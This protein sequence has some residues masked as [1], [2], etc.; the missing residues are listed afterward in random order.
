MRLACLVMQA[1]RSHW[2]RLA[3]LC[4]A[5]G[6]MAWTVSGKGAVHVGGGEHVAAVLK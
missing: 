1:A 2:V 4:D 6:F 5:G 3:C